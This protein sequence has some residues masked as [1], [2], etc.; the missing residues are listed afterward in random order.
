MTITAAT[1][2]ISAG[3]RSPSEWD[4]AIDDAL[5]NG[6]YLVQERVKTAKEIFR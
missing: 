3:I 1:G 6:D 2:S 5:G 4:D